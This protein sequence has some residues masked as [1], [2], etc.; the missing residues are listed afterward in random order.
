MFSSRQPPSEFKGSKVNRVNEVL[1]TCTMSTEQR[2]RCPM[3]DLEHLLASLVYPEVPG[4]FMD[5][6]WNKK[7]FAV[8]GAPPARTNE[9]VKNHLFDL[10]VKS[11][12]QSTVSPQ[13]F[14]WMKDQ[15]GKIASIELSEEA[16]IGCYECG[17]SLYF[18]APQE[19]SDALVSTIA[20]DTGMGFAGRYS[21]GELRG[22][23]EVFLSRK[24]HVTDWH[25]DYMQNFTIQLKGTKRWRLS[26]KNSIP[27][28]I[29]GCTPHYSGVDTIEQQ[30]KVHRLANPNF[31]YKSFK[32]HEVVTLTPG[33]FMYFPAGLWHKV[34][35]TED[36]V[37]I[38]IS[39]MPSTWSDLV[40]DGIKHMMWRDKSWR[41]GIA[42]LSYTK[43]RSKL[44]G[45]LYNL[46]QVVRRMTVHDLLP[47]GML[48]GEKRVVVVRG[49][50]GK[51]EGKGRRS[52]GDASSKPDEPISQLHKI[53]IDSE[54]ILRPNVL[55]VLIK[56]NDLRQAQ[57]ADMRH[58][59]TSSFC[60]EDSGDETDDTRASVCAVVNGTGSGIA[61]PNDK[62]VDNTKNLRKIQVSYNLH[63]NFGNEQ[64]ESASQIQF[65]VSRKLE[66]AMDF[67]LARRERFHLRDLMSRVN[68]VVSRQK[69]IHP[70]I[71]PAQQ[72]PPVGEVI[73]L[74]KN[75]VFYGKLVIETPKPESSNSR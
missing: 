11:L 31:H 8:L 74:L 23:V 72:P 7:A 21:N 50:D 22:E 9:L 39:M 69:H 18:R 66:T 70:K 25:F 68:E 36:S 67:L 55:A 65:V 32:I 71:P 60:S 57:N 3:I 37:S 16:A 14:A 5:T 28:P 46:K 49:S 34:E 4:K 54:T 30:M 38:N 63:I 45:L 40:G 61:N 13:I 27:N 73:Y 12:V 19:I 47:Q 35:C 26:S 33:S 17:A 1:Q 20:K 52:S 58:V 29:R 53:Q 2:G 56:E 44:H 42:N 41:E 64:L 75:M 24:G 59:S 43:A 15:S 62:S 48:G 51:S 6:I 10:D